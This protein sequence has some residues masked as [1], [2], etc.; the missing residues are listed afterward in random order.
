[1]NSTENEKCMSVMSIGLP[2]GGKTTFMVKNIITYIKEKL[3]TE[4]HLVLPSFGTDHAY[5]DLKEYLFKEPNN[6][7]FIYK[8]FNLSISKRCFA[9]KKK[10]KKIFFAVDDMYFPGH[11]P[12]IMKIYENPVRYNT[13]TWIYRLSKP[14]DWQIPNCLIIHKLLEYEFHCLLDS[15]KHRFDIREEHYD[16]RMFLDYG[17]LVLRQR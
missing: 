7:V 9:N 2:W 13:T 11:D 17:H 8:K 14:F 4:Y 12:I 10:K 16:D 15:V 6:N 3:F 5:D 1:M